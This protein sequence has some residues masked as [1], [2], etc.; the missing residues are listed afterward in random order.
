M[1]SGRKSGIDDPKARRKGREAEGGTNKGWVA[2]QSEM[3][4]D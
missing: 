2:T 4:T 3:E 1:A